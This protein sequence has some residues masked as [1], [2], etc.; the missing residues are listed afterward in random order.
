MFTIVTRGYIAVKAAIVSGQYHNRE[1][2]WYGGE[3][4][5]PS[6]V[7]FTGWLKAHMLDHSAVAMI[8]VHTGLGYDARDTLMVGWNAE[9]GEDVR[10]RMLN[11]FGRDGVWK[12]ECCRRHATGRVETNGTR[13]SEPPPI[14][15]NFSTK[16]GRS[17]EARKLG[18]RMLAARRKSLTSSWATRGVGSSG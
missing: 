8:D 3:Q 5:E 17:M 10:Q 7:A 13:D 1:G 15:R 11:M 4:L 9:M 12:G 2:V 18:T 6:L 14:L 16:S